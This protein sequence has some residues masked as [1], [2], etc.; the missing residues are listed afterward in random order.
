[1]QCKCKI[2]NKVVQFSANAVMARTIAGVNAPNRLLPLL[3]AT[4]F[5]LQPCVVHD[6]MRRL[7]Y[8]RQIQQPSKEQDTAA[9]RGNPELNRTTTFSQHRSRLIHANR[10][11]YVEQEDGRWFGSSKRKKGVTAQ[12]TGMRGIDK[13]YF[14]WNWVSVSRQDQGDS[15]G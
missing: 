6:Q 7:T 10:T 9:M 13:T 4:K 5:K 1:M 12:H 8:T 2:V 11:R 14:C 3:N 15:I